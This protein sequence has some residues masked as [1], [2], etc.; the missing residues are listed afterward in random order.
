MCYIINTS[1]EV[2]MAMRLNTLRQIGLLKFSAR[3]DGRGH[4]NGKEDSCRNVEPKLYF[5]VSK[6]ITISECSK[7]VLVQG[8]LIITS[9]TLTSNATS[10]RVDRMYLQKRPQE[11]LIILSN[12]S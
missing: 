1:D 3:L 5:H 8:R 10:V 11:I 9:L 12:C 4:R 7:V 6:V 2:C